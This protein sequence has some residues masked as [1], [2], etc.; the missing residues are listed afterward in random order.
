M[1]GVL[2]FWLGPG[3]DLVDFDFVAIFSVG[4]LEIFSVDVPCSRVEL[5][6][7]LETGVSNEGNTFF[8]YRWVWLPILEM[9]SAVLNHLELVENLHNKAHF[10]PHLFH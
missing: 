4:S 5:T 8:K 2:P 6:G 1:L 7:S 3:T 10:F 9:V